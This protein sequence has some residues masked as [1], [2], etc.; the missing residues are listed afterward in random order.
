MNQSDSDFIIPRGKCKGR[1]LADLS[2]SELH[3][4]WSGFNGS[5]AGADIAAI[6]GAEIEHR[7]GRPKTPDDSLAGD[8]RKLGVALARL[9]ATT[10]DVIAAT[11][12]LRREREGAMNLLRK[13]K[14]L[15]GDAHD[16]QSSSQSTEATE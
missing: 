10:E 11:E 12:K 15:M 6:L 2:D 14:V 1:K 4:S 13:L 5:S 16:K 7:K 3:L 8:D 9:V